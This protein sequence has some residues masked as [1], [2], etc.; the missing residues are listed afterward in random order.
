M[1]ERKKHQKDKKGF[2]T[3]TNAFLNQVP[4]LGGKGV[5]YTSPEANGSFYFRTWISEEKRY[6]RKGLRTKDVDVALKIGENEMLGI[7]KKINQGHKIFG[8][9]FGE[10]C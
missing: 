4:I 10:M 3:Q 1:V 5:I 7:L 6:V 8:V 9:T 2:K